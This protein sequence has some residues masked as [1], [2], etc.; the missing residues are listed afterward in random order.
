RARCW[1]CRCATRRWPSSA[2]WRPSPPPGSPTVA[3][4]FAPSLAA[5]ACAASLDVAFGEPP[6]RYHPVAWMG[7]AATWLVARAPA[8][9][10]AQLAFGA[11]LALGLPVACA[12]IG[13][14][15]AGVPGPEA[16]VAHLLL[17]KA[18]GAWRA[19]G[20]AGGRVRAALAA[21]DLAE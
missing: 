17:L 10:P 14:F 3:L 7:R 6:N 5:L 8:R 21:G 19:L 20:E 2:T 15:L 4:S 9:P 12:A 13:G 1:P 16:L 18:C 11:G